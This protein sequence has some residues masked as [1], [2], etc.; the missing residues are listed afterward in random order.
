MTSDVQFH[1]DV[2]Y[3]IKLAAVDET[4][5]YSIIWPRNAGMH[6]VSRSLVNVYILIYREWW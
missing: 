6:N 2:E 3:G 1:G 5:M 4:L